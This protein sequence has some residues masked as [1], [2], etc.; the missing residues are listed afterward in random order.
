[1]RRLKSFRSR[2]VFRPDP[3][4]LE[5]RALLSGQPTLTA[6]IASTAS[7]PSGRSVTFTATVSDLTAGGAIPNG[8]TVTFD[9]QDGTI[10]S[11]TLINGVATLATSSLAAGTITVTASYG[12]TAD[13][14]PS[15]TGTIV[16]AVGDG[17]AG[18]I[19]DNGPATAAE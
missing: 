9:D 17:T 2:V 18:Y 4:L 8:G 15:T 10:G 1:M 19:G 7:A 3:A 12:G 5:L 11:A 13:F 16:T 14:A 6:L